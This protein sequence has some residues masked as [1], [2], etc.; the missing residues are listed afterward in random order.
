MEEKPLKFKLT[1]QNKAGEEI[2]I[3]N[4]TSKDAS[5]SEIDV[6]RLV[7]AILHILSTPKPPEWR[8]RDKDRVT[9]PVVGLMMLLFF[10]WLCF[11]LFI[12]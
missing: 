1:Y 11:F 8:G 7:Y 12:P 2:Q 5:L 6:Q 3:C 4:I 9:H 10:F